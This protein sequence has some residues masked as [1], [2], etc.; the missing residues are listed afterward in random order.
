[1]RKQQPAETVAAV[2]VV[3]ALRDREVTR[4]VSAA[5]TWQR[6][7]GVVASGGELTFEEVEELEDAGQRLGIRDTASTFANDVEAARTVA[8]LEQDLARFSREEHTAAVAQTRQ[9]LKAAEQAVTAA[10]ARL[11]NLKHESDRVG[12]VR[13]TAIQLREANPRV[14]KTEGGDHV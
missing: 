11:A 8:A 6:L 3:S 9:D 2:G 13:A 4:Q 12:Q 1:M 10:R 5:S 14:F 7:A